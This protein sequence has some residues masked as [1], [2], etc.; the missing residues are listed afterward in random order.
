[1]KDDTPV[2]YTVSKVVNEA[3]NHKSI[4][5]K[6]RIDCKPGQFLM[7]WLPGVEEKPM[8]VSY[9]SKDEFA[10]TYHT[11]GKFTKGCD[12]LKV[13]DKMGIQSAPF[14]SATLAKS[15]IL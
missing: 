15:A 9:H 12:K 5:L 3:K 13:G 14:F 4:F 2:I 10:F 7:I 1:M 8:A 6:G 11:V